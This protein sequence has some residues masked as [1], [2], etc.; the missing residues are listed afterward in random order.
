MCHYGICHWLSLGFSD[1]I[2]H[3]L[4]D[5]EVKKTSGRQSDGW[6]VLIDRY[7][8][9]PMGKLDLDSAMLGPSKTYMQTTF[10]HQ[11]TLEYRGKKE[12][13]PTLTY[14]SGLTCAALH[15]L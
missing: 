1:Q 10:T 6:G 8:I 7:L 13:T 15:S 4:N 9:A 3:L 12:K 11:V 5:C 14:K 2:Q